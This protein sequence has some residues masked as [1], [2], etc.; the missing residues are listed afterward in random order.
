[1]DTSQNPANVT[2]NTHWGENIFLGCPW[3][4]ILLQPSRREWVRRIDPSTKRSIP[5]RCKKIVANEE[6]SSLRTSIKKVTK[7]D[8]NTNSYSMITIKTNALNRVAQDGDLVLRNSKLRI[9][10][11]PCHEVL[12]RIDRRYKQYE[13]ND[14]RKGLKDSLLF[15]KS[16]KETVN[17]KH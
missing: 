5:A 16:Y 11:Q 4:T 12:L 10:C 15:R 14:I 3:K 1:M 6:P 17:V 8:G 7:I 2:N 13:S 9:L